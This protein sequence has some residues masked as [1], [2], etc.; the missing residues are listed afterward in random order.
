MPT[1]ASMLHHLSF[2][3][4]D[5]ERSARFYDAVLLPLGYLRV[6]TETS[7][8]GYG[9]PGGGDAFAIKRGTNPR[10]PP[11]PGFHLA[12]AAPS[13]EAVLRFHAAALGYGGTDNG[14]PGPR[15]DYGEHYFAAFAID[16]D[17]YPIEA[18]INRPP[19]AA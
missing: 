8:I 11:G 3:V 15:P 2:A 5:L 4:H 14:A 19:G 12:F 1:S 16:P 18:V 17:G 7:A 13:R 10:V 6:W 9:L